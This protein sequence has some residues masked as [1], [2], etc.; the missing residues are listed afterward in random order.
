[1]DSFVLD[2]SSMI[3]LLKYAGKNIRSEHL[4]FNNIPSFLVYLSYNN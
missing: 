1:M 4:L 3:R 2:E